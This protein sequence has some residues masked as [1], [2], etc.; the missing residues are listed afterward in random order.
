MEK[1]ERLLGK[2]RYEKIP[3]IGTPPKPEPE[4][5]IE[6]AESMLCE[7]EDSEALLPPEDEEVDKQIE[8][9]SFSP[10]PKPVFRSAMPRLRSADFG[11]KSFN[12]KSRKALIGAPLHKP[13]IKGPTEVETLENILS[14]SYK[15]PVT[16][17]SINN[18]PIT[19]KQVKEVYFSKGGDPWLYKVWIFK[20]DPVETAKELTVYYIA[21]KKGVPTG[22][23]IGFKPTKESYQ[24][25]IA[26]LGGVVEHAGEPYNQL[27]NNMRFAPGRIHQTAEAIVCMIAD[28][29]AKLTAAK[30]EFEE[31]GISLEKA[32]PEKEIEGRFLAKLGIEK[33]AANVLIKACKDLY[34]QQSD[35]SVISHGDIHT[36]NIVTEEIR[37]AVNT[38]RF[39]LIDWGSINLDNPYGD[40]QDFWLH[41]QRQA[42]R[43]CGAYDFGFE[44][45]DKA[46]QASA[47][48]RG[49][50]L[51]QKDMLV[52]SALWNLYEMYD[53]TREN[54]LEI[55]EKAE[56]HCQALLNDLEKLELFGCRE[57]SSIIKKELK[58]LLKDHIYLKPILQ[59]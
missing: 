37:Y 59:N 35:I 29:H 38:D 43:A 18:L 15:L 40:L 25:D 57:Q 34:N 36:G 32:S 1:L 33:K 48:R 56:T 54:P 5:G 53:P 47:K 55:K 51:T 20:A 23:P 13:P 39:G 4:I 58:T 8:S 46:Y 12:T 30:D 24:F 9:A 3:I 26:I 22:K 14:L 11:V 19:R 7:F 42:L 49:I 52:Q 21:N 50:S 41:H 10:E 27:I 2:L 45:L 6:F 44:E 17:T 28:C 31:Y 16:I